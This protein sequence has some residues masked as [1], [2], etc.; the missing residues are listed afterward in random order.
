MAKQKTTH[1][2]W[3]LAKGAVRTGCGYQVGARTPAVDRWASVD[4]AV[5][6]GNA[7]WLRPMVASSRAIVAAIE[8]GAQ[9]VDAAQAGA[10]AALAMAGCS[11]G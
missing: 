6:L 5:C 10:R 3:P 7:V 11:H 2:Y 1:Y 8:M 9:P 4:C